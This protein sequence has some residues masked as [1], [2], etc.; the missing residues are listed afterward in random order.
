MV[1]LAFII[2][3]SP[4]LVIWRLSEGSWFVVPQGESFMVWLPVYLPQLLFSTYR[5]ILAWMP[6]FFPALL[7]LTMLARRQPHHYLP[8]LLVLVA[9]VYVNASTP[10]WMGCG[11]YGPRRLSSELVI[12]IVGYSALLKSLSRYS[13]PLPHV[14]NL[15]LIIHQLILFKFGLQEQLGGR[16]LSKIADTYLIVEAMPWKEFV[17]ELF[18]RLPYLLHPETYQRPPSLLMEAVQGTLSWQQPIFSIVLIGFLVLLLGTA[19]RLYRRYLCN[20]RYV[21]MFLTVSI[22]VSIFLLNLWLSLC[23]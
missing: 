9:Q 21:P 3:L 13:P 6:L 11:G 1:M 20:L 10:D 12:M 18:Y 4:Q 2:G 5:G 15:G 7:G 23:A 8:L 19:Y 22:T 17:R 16:A 14:L